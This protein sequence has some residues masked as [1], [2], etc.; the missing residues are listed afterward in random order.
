MSTNGNSYKWG[1]NLTASGSVIRNGW[2]AAD[3]AWSS[4]SNFNLFEHSNSVNTLNSWYES[5]SSYYGKMSTYVNQTTKIVTKFEG[6][7]NSGNTN[8]SK[9]N[10]AKSTAVHEFGHAMGI[11]H[12]SGTSIMNSQR[13]RETMHVPQTDDK[14]GI[15]AIYY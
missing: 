14:N 3:N 1:N 11:G 10:V 9:T 8:I 5:S 13:N 4:A 12:N 7:L 2:I 6:Y 15:R